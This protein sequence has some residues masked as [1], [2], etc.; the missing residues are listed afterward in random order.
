MHITTWYNGV[1]IHREKRIIYAKFLE[2]HLVLSTCRV[3]GGMRAD[4]KYVLNHQSCEPCNHTHSL[5][6]RDPLAYRKDICNPYNLVPEKCATMGTAANMHHAAFVRKTYQNL[7]VAAVVTPGYMKN[8]GFS[9][10]S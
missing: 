8:G 1:E 4:L 6:L 3:A 10:T 9:M 5:V 2:P 7:E